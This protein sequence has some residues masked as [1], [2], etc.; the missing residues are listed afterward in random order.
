MNIFVLDEDPVAA[1]RMLCDQHVV[2][3]T[4]ETAQLLCSAHANGAAPYRRTH[5]DHPCAVWTR[6]STANYLWLCCH[7]QALADEYTYRFDREHASE[8]VV[9][10]A[11]E[12]MATLELRCHA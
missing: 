1:A 9:R 11:L 10:W 4:L 5:Y 2:K 7:G 3:M 12:H 8:R 6:A